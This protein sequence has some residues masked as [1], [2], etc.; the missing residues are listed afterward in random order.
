VAETD[1][2]SLLSLGTDVWNVWRG[3]NP[4][5]QPDLREANLS[6][7]NLSDAMLNGSDLSDADLSGVNLSSQ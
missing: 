1:H 6:R 7:A 3:A 5:I 2:I 4:A